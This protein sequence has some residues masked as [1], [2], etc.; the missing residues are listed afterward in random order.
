MVTI[1]LAF[2]AHICNREQMSTQHCPTLRSNTNTNSSKPHN[3]QVASN[4]AP[5]KVVDTKTGH[6]WQNKLPQEATTP[7]AHTCTQTNTLEIQMSTQ[8]GP[9]SRDGLRLQ[10]WRLTRWASHHP[11]QSITK[12]VTA[13]KDKIKSGSMSSSEV[14][15]AHVPASARSKK[16][17][18]FLQGL[19]GTPYTSYSVA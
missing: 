15:A 4:S 3:K 14:E 19:A 5:F 6:C 11:G 9:T 13:T 7:Y 16:K 1:T 8:G 18:A 10:N 17:T 12:E 2:T